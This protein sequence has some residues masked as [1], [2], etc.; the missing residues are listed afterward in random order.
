MTL[1]EHDYYSGNHPAAKAAIHRA[2]R[3]SPTVRC[4]E[5]DAA[6]A[7][8][9]QWLLGLT[10]TDVLRQRTVQGVSANFT[11]AVIAASAIR[12][13]RETAPEF[14]LSLDRQSR[15]GLTGKPQKK[16]DGPRLGNAKPPLT[17]PRR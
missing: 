10:R 5:A 14:E 11:T 4:D 13:N 15:K 16:R 6:L 8:A 17:R 7:V 9:V 2:F 12:R 3:F 1:T